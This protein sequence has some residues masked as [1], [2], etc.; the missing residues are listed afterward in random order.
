MERKLSALIVDDEEKAVKLLGSLLEDTTQFSSIHTASSAAAA[1][2]ELEEKKPDLVF[3]DVKM[4]GKD[5]ITFLSELRAAGIW[6][7]IIFVTAYDKYALEA[8]RH[9]AFGYLLKPVN[10]KDLASCI[11]HFRSHRQGPSAMTR[12]D[13]FLE[14]FK[15][16]TRLRFDTRSGYFFV[17]PTDIYYCRADGNYSFIRTGD[18]EHICSLQL[19][20]VQ[21]RLPA[22]GFLRLGR[23]L[24]VNFKRVTRVDRRKKL[25]L[26]EK[27]GQSVAIAVSNSQLR[28][29]D[30]IQLG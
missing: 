20:K 30:K 27:G 4:P 12:L 14:E 21:E 29:L 18:K 22:N 10:R 3:L 28:E 8:I 19:G 16:E 24:I 17:D 2:T 9:H 15:L 13:Q 7:E 11:E 26:F 23:S 6:T 1:I 25:L 5:G